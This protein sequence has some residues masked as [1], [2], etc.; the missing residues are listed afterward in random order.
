MYNCV[1]SREALTS[2]ATGSRCQPRITPQNNSHFRSRS[3]MFRV[4]QHD[5]DLFFS[6]FARRVRRCLYGLFPFPSPGS[7]RHT[8]EGLEVRSEK[9]GLC[10]RRHGTEKSLFA[11]FFPQEIE[12]TAECESDRVS[13]QRFGNGFILFAVSV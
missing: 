6:D 12:C 7:P 5:K 8:G 10:L 11:F 1:S 9:D 4:A 13:V 2:S 3:E